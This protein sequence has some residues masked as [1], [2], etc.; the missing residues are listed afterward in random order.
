[1]KV[2]ILAQENYQTQKLTGLNFL[3]VVEG[4]EMERLG[5]KEQQVL[6][7]QQVLL[8]LMERL[9]LKVLQG[10]LVRKELKEQQ[11]L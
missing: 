8:G 3:L 6:Q 4:V 7:G 5:L 11:V 2:E 1:V 9:D 10:L